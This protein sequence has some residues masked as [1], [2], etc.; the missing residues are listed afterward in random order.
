VTEELSLKD[1]KKKLDIEV[2]AAELELKKLEIKKANA[3]ALSA[4]LAAERSEYTIGEYRRTEA[5]RKANEERHRVFEFDT[6]V[7][8]L[9]VA[10][11]SDWL[12]DR[13]RRFPEKELTLYINSPGGSIY[14]GFVAMDAIR[15]AEAAGN[16]VTV[17]ITGMAASMAGVIAQAASKRLIG[18]H[19]E[20][21]LH[22]VSNFQFG[23]FKTF[24]V[25]DQAKFMERL[26]KKCLEAYAARSEWTVENLFEKV[27]NGRVDWWLTADEAVA[28]GFMDGT[29]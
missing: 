10:N 28:E 13:V 24:D 15:E 8:D 7:S 12:R 19:S 21:M 16:P 11:L 4:E 20:L 29:F 17:K 5:A 26:T 9:E 22:T 27:N 1:R 6:E 2:R 23:S 14:S 3:E 18:K 25:Q